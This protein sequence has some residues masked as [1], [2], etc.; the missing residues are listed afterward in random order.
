MADEDKKL[1]TARLTNASQGSSIDN[2]I[3]DLEAA[4]RL[5]FGVTADTVMAEAM[6]ISAAGNVTMTG[7]LTLA[8]A[9]TDASH[10]ATKAYVDAL[11]GAEPEFAV[12]KVTMSSGQTIGTGS[13][14]EL[15]WDSEVIDP[16][17]CHSVAAATGRI[18]I[19]AGK[20]G[21]YYVILHFQ[22]STNP[23]T[24]DYSEVVIKKN[25]SQVYLQQHDH[26]PDGNNSIIAGTLLGLA[27][28]DYVQAYVY[29]TSGG[30]LTTHAGEAYISFSAFQIRSA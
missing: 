2:S 10:A 23:G 17:G 24:G 20:G 30:N 12:C 18:T 5:I 19:P 16:D 15:L 11:S 8:G 22:W 28:G 6:S 7:D 14:T 3:A 29:Q 26:E 25:G 21:Y 4:L 1:M 9:P 27:E 13:S